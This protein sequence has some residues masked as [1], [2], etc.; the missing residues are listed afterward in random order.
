MYVNNTVF[1]ENHTCKDC[2]NTVICKW[3]DKM[4]EVHSELSNIKTALSPI[5]VNVNCNSFVKKNTG[6]IPGQREY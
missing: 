5:R 6:F 3:C 1:I 2:A 4:K